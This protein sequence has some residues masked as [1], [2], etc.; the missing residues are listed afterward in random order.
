MQLGLRIDVDTRLGLQEGVP[1]LLDLFRRY[2]IHASF[3]VTFGPD[4]SGRAI[5]R[6][7]RPSFI[8]KMWR[9]NPF[10]LY[11]F[12]TL[13]AGTLLPALP[14][15]EGA[16]ELLKEIVSEGHEL[17][18]HGYDHVRWQDKLDGMAE[19]EIESEL[20][21][22]HD[23]YERIIGAP[24]ASTAAP[25][26]KCTTRSL[27]VQDKFTFLYAS[28]V[29]GSSAFL[30]AHNGSSFST[31]QLPTTFPTMD[32]LL[33]RE[34]DINGCL[35]SHLKDGLNIHTIHAEVEGRPYFSLFEKFLAEVIQKQVSVAR[36]RDL[37]EEILAGDSPKPPLNSVVRNT[38]PGRSGWVA[39][40]GSPGEMTSRVN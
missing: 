25:G 33:G 9:T 17:G 31:L 20:Q 19:T 11:G 22:A 35:L 14:V 16:P 21:K 36:L 6:I 12:K 27:A 40:Q 5:K 3:F 29:R 18:I 32:E 26:W 24:P 39:C 38:V 34:S 23:A 7:L 28:D 15:G 1:R 37:A 13:L 10:R 8:A 30:P 4:H 2:S